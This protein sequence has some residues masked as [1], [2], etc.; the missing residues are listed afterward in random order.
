[1]SNSWLSGNMTL[2]H[3]VYAKLHWKHLCSKQENATKTQQRNKEQFQAGKKGDWC[4]IQQTNMPSKIPCTGPLI[5]TQSVTHTHT[6]RAFTHTQRHTLNTGYCNWN[7]VQWDH[8]LTPSWPVILPLLHLHSFFFLP[9]HH[10]SSICSLSSSLW[11]GRAL[12]KDSADAGRHTNRHTVFPHTHTHTNTWHYGHGFLLSLAFLPPHF[13][14]KDSTGESLTHTYTHTTPHTHTHTHTN[15][16]T[17]SFLLFQIV[18]NGFQTC[19]S[20]ITPIQRHTL[21]HT[22]THI[23]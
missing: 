13:V 11:P 3:T 23:H 7:K 5:H 20:F 16:R 18:A 9:L 10:L 14:S 19:I 15:T 4:I 17:F 1:M 6:Q 2:R 22:Q 8:D 21:T 12:C